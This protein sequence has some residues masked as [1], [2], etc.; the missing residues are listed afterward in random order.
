MMVAW[1]ETGRAES[2]LRQQGREMPMLEVP[3]VLEKSLKKDCTHTGAGGGQGDQM[4][5]A[6]Q[7]RCTQAM[8]RC[9]HI[10]PVTNFHQH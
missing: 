6:S 9:M 2:S 5:R 7:L 8:G 1:K 3:L 10:W 4:V